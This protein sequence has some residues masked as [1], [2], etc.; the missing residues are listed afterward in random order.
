VVYSGAGVLQLSEMA[1]LPAHHW[2]QHVRTNGLWQGR[3]CTAHLHRTNV[4]YTF[5][6]G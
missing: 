2:E 4:E 3:V 1:A 5:T 6:T